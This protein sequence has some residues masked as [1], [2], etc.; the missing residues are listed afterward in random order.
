MIHPEVNTSVKAFMI[1]HVAE[2]YSTK[3]ERAM[4]M[5]HCYSSTCNYDLC[6]GLRMVNE[7]GEYTFTC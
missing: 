4:V 3:D 7:D 2:I 6:A 5:V 1:L